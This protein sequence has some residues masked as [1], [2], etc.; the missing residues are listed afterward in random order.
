MMPGLLACA[1]TVPLPAQGA[2]GQIN[3]DEQQ[4]PRTISVDVNLVNVLVSVRN[5]QGRLIP[6]LQ[7]SDFAVL[8]DGKM[9]SIRY[10]NRQAD[11]PL[12]IGLL[13]DVSPSQIRFIDIERRSAAGFLATVLR[14]KDQAFLIQFGGESELL[15]DYTNSPAL[16]D[17]AL[18]RVHGLGWRTVLYDCIYLAASEKLK[19]EVGRKTLI[20]LTDGLDYGSRLSLSD[21]IEAAQGRGSVKDFV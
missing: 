12:T 13:V 14:P 9:Q 17:H 21:A 19:A 15:Q 18:S 11:L 6:D 20:V 10:F 4:V 3:P 5:K 16:L 2:S 7:K 8:E 1:L